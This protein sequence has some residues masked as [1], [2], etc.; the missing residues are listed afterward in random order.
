MADEDRG[1]EPN[2]DKKAPRLPLGTEADLRE[3]LKPFLEKNPEAEFD[4]HRRDD[5]E[6]V[7]IKKPWGDNTLLTIIREEDREELFR[8]L[9]NIRL[10][11][12]LSAIWHQETGDIE[13]IWTAYKL[14]EEQEE[15]AGRRF[16]FRDNDTEYDCEFGISSR[17]LLA[18]ARRTFPISTPS[19]T[20][21]RNL[22]SFHLYCYRDSAGE[23]EI[24]SVDEPRSFWI[25][26][27]RI[28]EDE[29]P[30]FINRLSFYITY[31]D[32]LSPYVLIHH[33]EPQ[34]PEKRCRY[35]RG[36]FPKEINGLNLD[37]NI[38]SFWLA[39]ALEESLLKYILYYRII[40]YAAHH[41]L[42]MKMRHK[43][44]RI[45]S[46]PAGH[47][48]KA[49]TVER[50][51]ESMDPS[52]TDETTRFRNV[53]EELVDP[54][55]IWAEVERNKEAFTKDIV[56]DGGYLIK[57]ISSEKETFETFSKGGL[58]KF[59]ERLKHIRNVLAH[60]RDQ[61]TGKVITPTLRNVNILEPWVSALHVAAGEV[62]AYE[63]NV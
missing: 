38:L 24:S 29:L 19:E 21:F 27:V 2:D 32:S 26:N 8:I 12:R 14:M 55:L 50:L 60:G 39:A 10:P 35:I 5:K 15:I 56:C 6:F 34:S 18:V 54:T 42:D 61:T 49:A 25:R 23:E 11:P 16:I 45:L 63:S 28:G 41:H 57:A 1:F 46:D 53:I 17:S 7:Y 22:T 4:F 43:I 47:R 48:N 31:F 52:R 3:A 44:S 59:A 36:E 40:E 20:A 30:R 62:A 33:P 51:M 37:D 9:N 58:S 13:V